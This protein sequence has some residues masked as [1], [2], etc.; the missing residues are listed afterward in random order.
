MA[1]INVFARILIEFSG[2]QQPTTVHVTTIDPISG[3]IP[4]SIRSQSDLTYGLRRPSRVSDAPPIAES[5][6]DFR[7]DLR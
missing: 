6:D 3:K 4:T 2:Q 7:Y 5:F 1:G